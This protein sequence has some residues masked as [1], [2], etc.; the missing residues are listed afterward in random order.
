[1]VQTRT[2]ARLLYVNAPLRPKRQPRG[3]PPR[4]VPLPSEPCGELTVV[5]V[6]GMMWV[7]PGGYNDQSAIPRYGGSSVKFKSLLDRWKKTAAPPKTVQ[8]YS[9]RLAVDDAARLHALSELFPG[10]PVEGILS[11]LLRVSLEEISAAMP[12]ERGSKVISSDEQGDPIYEDVGLTPRFVE[13]TRKFK[14]ELQAAA[15][16]QQA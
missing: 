6:L 8:E 14:K 1:M 7:G 12:Y 16:R 13:L 9:F 10:Q 11:D 15:A 4:G 5:D 3:E 2:S